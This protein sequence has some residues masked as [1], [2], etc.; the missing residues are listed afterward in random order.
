[1]KRSY[2]PCPSCTCHTFTSNNKDG[3]DNVFTRKNSLRKK[4][5]EEISDPIK[6]DRKVCERQVIK[7]KKC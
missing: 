2:K 3:E 6:V 4:R 5:Q 1:M 7:R